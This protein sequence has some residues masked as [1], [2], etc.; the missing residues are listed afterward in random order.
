MNDIRHDHHYRHLSTL[1][2][3]HTFEI[4]SFNVTSAILKLTET[5]DN[6]PLKVLLS[7]SFRNT[8]TWLLVEDL[9][10]QTIRIY[11]V[12]FSRKPK[13]ETYIINIAFEE[14]ILSLSLRFD[15]APIDQRYLYDC[16]K[17]FFALAPVKSQRWREICSIMRL[18]RSLGKLDNY[19]QVAGFTALAKALK[20]DD[21]AILDKPQW[22][23]VRVYSNEPVGDC[24]R[25]GQHEIVFTAE[26]I[27][28]L[29][30]CRNREQNEDIIASEFSMLTDHKETEFIHSKKKFLIVKNHR[31]EAVKCIKCNAYSSCVEPQ[32]ITFF[33]PPK[34]FLIVR[35]HINSL[36]P[37]KWLSKKEGR[38]ESGHLYKFGG[39]HDA[40]IKDKFLLLRKPRVF[41][42]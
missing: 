34:S 22:H 29:V 13:H 19:A 17:K 4:Q 3:N 27:E 20:P 28:V 36:L 39:L 38:N 33:I 40:T 7:K 35:H 11:F 6:Y 9:I 31:N 24:P 41:K 5:L 14:E 26:R 15:K 21:I 30:I 8:L 2:N 12:Y 16:P 1:S 10:S 42:Y 32:S 37:S 18:E 23:D 25:G